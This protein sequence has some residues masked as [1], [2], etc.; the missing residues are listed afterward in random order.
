MRYLKFLLLL[1]SLSA[2]TAN[3]Q[4][5]IARA[6]FAGGCFWCM[7]ADFDKVFGVTK[8]TAGYDGGA[9]KNPT[10]ETVSSGATHFVE[11]VEVSYDTNKVSYAKLLNYYWQ[12]I[13]P[14]VKNR[15]FCDVG[16]QYRS[17]SQMLC[18]SE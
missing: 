3:V 18:M 9:Q 5:K 6:V 10:Y 12:H 7:E 8:T 15:Q 4:A 1:L 13:D 2:V 16:S 14:T 17:Y 11:S